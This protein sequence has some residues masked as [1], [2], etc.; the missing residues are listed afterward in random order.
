MTDLEHVIVLLLLKH[1][2]A[3]LQSLELISVIVEVDCC[4]GLL[5]EIRAFHFNLRI[6]VRYGLIFVLILS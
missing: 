6:V 2:I 1:L 5:Q 3:Q 4:R